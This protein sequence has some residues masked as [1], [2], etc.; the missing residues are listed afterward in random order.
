MKP[1][2]IVLNGDKRNVAA[3][4]TVRDLVAQWAQ[5]RG[6]V[7]VEVN[8]TIVRRDDWANLK[9]RSGDRIEIVH[10]VGGGEE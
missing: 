3:D 6:P 7:A 8:E 9:L 5:A 10:F 1:I 2:E 4:T